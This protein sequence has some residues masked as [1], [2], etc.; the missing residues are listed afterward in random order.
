[1]DNGR[2]YKELLLTDRFKILLTQNHTSR[3][4]YPYVSRSPCQSPLFVENKETDK[5]VSWGKKLQS[6]DI[7]SA[8]EQKLK[9]CVCD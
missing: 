8:E 7:C 5:T 1:M 9:R 4:V 2:S 3:D 6:A